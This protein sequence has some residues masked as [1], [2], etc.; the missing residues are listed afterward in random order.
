MVPVQTHLTGVMAV[1]LLTGGTGKAEV[2]L[3]RSAPDHLG[4]TQE[5]ILLVHHTV[6]YPLQTWQ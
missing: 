4:A 3:K 1:L 5:Q 2:H 6:E